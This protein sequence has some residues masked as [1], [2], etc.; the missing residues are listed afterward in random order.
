MTGATGVRLLL[1]DEDRQD[2][3]L[4]APGGGTMP[5]SDGGREG[6]VPMSVLR[7]VQRTGEPLVAD[8]ATRDD[9]FS[10][11]PCFADAGC[12]SL[13][14]VP[15]LSRGVLRA[16]LLLENRLIRAAFTTGRLDAVNLIAA[17]LTV[18]L[19]NA[20]LYAEYR[21]IADEHRRIAGEQ[22]A[23]RRVATLVARAAPR[24]RRCSP[25]SP[26]RPGG[27]FGWMSPS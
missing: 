1:R 23:L 9:R 26:R 24:R 15:I 21:R 8:D 3:L 27:C 17:Q 12:C 5:A 25:R 4:P 16:V 10:R 6:A 22:A 11:D 20:Q 13:L 2:W 14:A 7:Y 19:D 18:S